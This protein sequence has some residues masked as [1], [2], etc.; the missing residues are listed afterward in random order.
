MNTRQVINLMKELSPLHNPTLDD[1]IWLCSYYQAEE[2]EEMSTKEVA[3]MLANN[4]LGFNNRSDC[5]NYIEGRGWKRSMLK[6]IL[7][8]FGYTETFKG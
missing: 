7:I 4:Q 1:V 8:D 2:L 6:S 5:D 3:R